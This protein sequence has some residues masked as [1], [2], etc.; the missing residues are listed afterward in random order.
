MPNTRD[1]TPHADTARTLEAG[2]PLSSVVD[3]LR[4]AVEAGEGWAVMLWLAYYWGRPSQR[5]RGAAMAR[6]SVREASDEEL[7]E[8]MRGAAARRASP[9]P[10]G[11]AG[12]PPDAPDGE[13]R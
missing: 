11:E 7:A 2:L 4:E 3:K 13:E 10:G 1:K 6:R 8:A 12:P 5:T 9:A